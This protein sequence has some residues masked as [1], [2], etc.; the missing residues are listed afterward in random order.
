MRG[1]RLA[2]PEEQQPPPPRRRQMGLTVQSDVM[3][4][5]DDGPLGLRDPLHG[6]AD[7]AKGSLHVMLLQ[8]EPARFG[9]LEKSHFYATH[10]HTTR[11]LLQSDANLFKF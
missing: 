1:S 6:A 9:K 11:P 2:K 10:T 3:H 8:G 7:A 5:E 4:G